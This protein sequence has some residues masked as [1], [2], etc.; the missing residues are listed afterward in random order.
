MK[1][2]IPLKFAGTAKERKDFRFID[3]STIMIYPYTEKGT[4][5]MEIIQDEVPLYATRTLVI[6]MEADTIINAE[7]GR[8]TK[9]VNTIIGAQEMKDCSG[10]NRFLR[11]NAA[12]SSFELNASKSRCILSLPSSFLFRSGGAEISPEVVPKLSSFLNEIRNRYELEGDAIRVDGHTDDVPIT[13]IGKYKNNWEL[14]T[15]RAT[16]VA[17]LMM[18]NVGF[19]P[20]RIAISGYA[21]T[22]PKSP[23]LN[24]EGERKSGKELREARN[25]NRRVELIFTRPVKKERTRKF[26][27]DPDAG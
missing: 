7:V 12:F 22:R 24:K 2:E 17:T 9:Q 5:E 1:T 13:T 8:T 20:E 27:P 21:E 25:A 6:Q 18:E 16:N 23:Y 10:I 19:N 26:F 15:M 4:I 11:E 3:G 14:S